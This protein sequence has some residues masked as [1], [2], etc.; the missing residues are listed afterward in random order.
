MAPMSTS[1]SG[2]LVFWPQC[3]PQDLVPTVLWPQGRPQD[4]FIWRSG[5]NVDLN[6]WFFGFLV[7]MSTPRSGYLVFWPQC[8]PQNL[9]PT[10]LRPQC[11]PQ[12]RVFW[13]SG[14][15]VDIN[16]WL[17]PN[18]VYLK[19][20]YSMSYRIGSVTQSRGFPQQSKLQ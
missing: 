6:I 4:L 16:I 20:S 9:V 11:R 1:N 7:S 5:P 2:Y 10:V 18:S 19:G 13:V 3:R 12:N 17:F 8:R 15:N 14:P